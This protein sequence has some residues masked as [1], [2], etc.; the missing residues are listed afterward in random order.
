[1]PVNNPDDGIFAWLTFTT[2]DG[3]ARRFP[4]RQAK[5]VIG[6]DHHSD[7]RLAL[8]A[9]A[10]RQCEIEIKNGRAHVRHLVTADGETKAT[11]TD[12]GAILA[13][14]DPLDIAGL[15]FV[16]RYGDASADRAQHAD[17]PKT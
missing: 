7:I 2:Q 13:D 14:G 12:D 8:P 5:T 9:V 16:I 4:L 17:K 10:P 11:T 3:H 1:M 6:R 15:R